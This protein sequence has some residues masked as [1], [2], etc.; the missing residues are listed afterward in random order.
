MIIFRS[1]ITETD[2][3]GKNYNGKLLSHGGKEVVLKK[4]DG[5][6]VS[7][8]AI[9]VKFPDTSELLTK[10][11]L[12]WQIY[13]PSSEKRGLIISY[14][15]G[16]LS[17]NVNYIIQTNADSTKADIWSWASINNNAGITFDDAK[18]KLVAEDAHKVY[19][20]GSI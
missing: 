12:L 11:T 13:S 4:D 17:W 6:V 3:I 19:G 7:L 1:K 16:G 15:I 14:L 18:L 10:P 9:T 8:D 20:L 2:R 5:S